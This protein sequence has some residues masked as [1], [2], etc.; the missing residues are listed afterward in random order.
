MQLSKTIRHRSLP[1]LI[2]VLLV[3]GFAWLFTLHH[4][5]RVLDRYFTDHSAYLAQQ[6][7]QHESENLRHE[8][9]VHARIASS[10]RLAGDSAAESRALHNYYQRVGHADLKILSTEGRLLH[11]DSASGIVP[12]PSQLKLLIPD[13]DSDDGTSVGILPAPEGLALVAVAVIPVV[14]QFQRPEAIFMLSRQLDDYALLELG[15]DYG[16]TDL[17]IANEHAPLASRLQLSYVDGSP[18]FISWIAP[19]F[20]R[21]LLRDLIPVIIGAALLLAL[22]VGLIARDAIRTASKLMASYNQLHASRH[23]LETSEMRF[24]DI[25]EA[26]S[27]WLWETDAQLRLVYLS[28]RFEAITGHAI[29]DWLGRPLP[30]LLQG[31][32]LDLTTWLESTDTGVLRCQYTDRLGNLR[33]SQLASRPIF[34]GHDCVGYRGAASDITERVREQSEIEHLAL[35]DALTGLANRVRLQS[36]LDASLAAGQP[37]ALLSLDLDRFKEVNDNFGH[38]AGDAVLKEV[39]ERL[40]Q[41]VRTQDLVA[42]LGGDEF[43]LIICGQISRANIDQLCTRI[44]ERLGQPIQY[45]QHQARIGTSIGIAAAPEHADDSDSLMRCADVALYQAKRAGRETWRYY[46]EQD[47]RRK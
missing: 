7:I 32:G 22:L 12:S 47:D 44:I 20:G 4:V 13:P 11:G 18:L 8:A 9:L 1:Q 19:T 33:I 2:G 6:A 45:Q 31:D 15:F 16:L 34:E 43:I 28:G 26:A 17:R 41:C 3:A 29:S 39:S 37:L 38:A 35:H 40:L 23:Q 25:A 24:R 10:Y 27:D 5:T 42:R 21:E 46:D 36:F 14:G 30:D